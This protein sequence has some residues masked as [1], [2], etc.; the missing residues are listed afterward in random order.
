[1]ARTVTAV[2]VVTRAGIAPTTPANSDHTNGNTIANDGSVWIEAT[3][4]DSVTRTLTI[5]PNVT[6][7]G[8]G[9]TPVTHA[10]TAALVR[11]YGPFPVAVYG[12]QLHL[13]TDADLLKVAAYKL[14]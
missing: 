12:G 1:M 5:T 13:D 7:D 10:L 14:A 11:R 8:Q 3:N 9:V 4:A 2:A 6:V